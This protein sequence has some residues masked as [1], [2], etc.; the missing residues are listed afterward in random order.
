[1][2][3]A[4]QRGAGC[5]VQEAEGFVADVA[6]GRNSG[7]I[8]QMARLLRRGGGELGGLLVAPLRLRQPTTDEQQ[9]SQVRG[10]GGGTRSATLVGGAPDQRGADVVNDAVEART[11]ALV[12]VS[13]RKCRHLGTAPLP[14]AGEDVVQLARGHELFDPVLPNRLERSVAGRFTTLDGQQAVAG[15]PR[16]TVGHCGTLRR[17]PA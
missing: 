12:R 1:M 14:V 11:P 16:Q 2:S 17:R 5:G 15:E 9:P 6:A 4:A 13:R 3:P 8:P 7:G 10:E